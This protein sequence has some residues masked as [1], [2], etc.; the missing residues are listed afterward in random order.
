LH[1]MSFNVTYFPKAAMNDICAI[2]VLLPYLYNHFSTLP[3]IVCYG[4]WNLKAAIFCY[5]YHLL[6]VYLN[7]IIFLIHFS[8]FD[9]LF[10]W[11]VHL[12]WR[13]YSIIIYM[14][15]NSSHFLPKLVK[16]NEYK[17][18]SLLTLIFWESES[19]SSDDTPIVL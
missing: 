12:R 18:L 15:F 2:L 8:Y 13:E 1:S 11:C 3:A 4:I 5:V 19:F 16:S 6:K 7:L 17:F 10:C 9:L 14:I